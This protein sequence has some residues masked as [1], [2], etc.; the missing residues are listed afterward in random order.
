MKQTSEEF[1]NAMLQEDVNSNEENIDIRE[2]LAKMEQTIQDRIDSVEK[3]ILEKVSNETL[4]EEITEDETEDETEEINN[5]E[6]GE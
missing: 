1:V 5:D 4:N 3:S 2:T 6:E